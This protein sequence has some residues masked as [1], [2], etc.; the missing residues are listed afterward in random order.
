MKKLQLLFI[1]TMLTC[2]AGINA[3]DGSDRSQAFDKALK[4]KAHES[5]RGLEQV[6]LVR[7]EEIGY[8]RKK[9]IEKHCDEQ[10][11]N[12]RFIKA[13]DINA[14][15]SPEL[16]KFVHTYGCSLEVEDGILRDA[17]IDLQ[18]AEALAQEMKTSLQMC[19][20]DERESIENKYEKLFDNISTSTYI[21]KDQNISRIINAIRMKKIIDIHNLDHLD[22]ADKFLGNRFQSEGYV[23]IKAKRVESLPLRKFSL[24]DIQQLAQLAEKTGYSDWGGSCWR[25][26]NILIN[27]NNQITFIDTEDKSFGHPGHDISPEYRYNQSVPKISDEQCRAMPL[28]CKFKYITNLAKLYPVMEP[29]AQEWYSKRVKK[30]NSPEG[31]ALQPRIYDNIQYDD[32]EIDLQEVKKEWRE[33]G[34]SEQDMFEIRKKSRV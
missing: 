32:P 23:T 26:S 1:F 24:T 4:R 17:Q 30:L 13:Q 9:A 22:V 7:E 28:G 3:S 29:K 12:T 27:K 25:L 21:S 2:A 10:R 31:F 18:K 19:K 20:K 5:D 33:L 6:A 8:E 34:I 15:E 16:T 14:L 11:L